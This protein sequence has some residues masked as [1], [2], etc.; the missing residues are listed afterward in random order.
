M[1]KLTC[2]KTEFSKTMAQLHSRSSH[3]TMSVGNLIHLAPDSVNDPVCLRHKY[4][5][6]K[7]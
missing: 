6:L 2:P 1:K 5:K 7:F 3:E 4:N